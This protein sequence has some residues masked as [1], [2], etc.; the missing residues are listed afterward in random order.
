MIFASYT[1]QSVYLVPNRL[2]AQRIHHS[3]LKHFNIEYNQNQALALEL[4]L[5]TRLLKNVILEITIGLVGKYIELPDAYK[6]VIESLQLTSYELNVNLKLKYIQPRNVNEDNLQTIV[7]G[8][9][10]LFSQPWVGQ[11]MVFLVVY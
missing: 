7:D 10:V 1:E 8:T 6:S 2:F 3:I 11:L 9:M 4:V 5:Q